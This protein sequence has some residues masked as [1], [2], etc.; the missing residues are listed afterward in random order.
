[1]IIWQYVPT[2]M[3]LHYI[4]VCYSFILMIFIVIHYLVRCSEKEI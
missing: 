3:S 1:M 4:N 2:G